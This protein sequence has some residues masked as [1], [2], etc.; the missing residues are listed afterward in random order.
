MQS[1]HGA[2]VEYFGDPSFDDSLGEDLQ[3]I[4]LQDM[5]SHHTEAVVDLE[6]FPWAA[7]ISGQQAGP[8]A[9]SR[10]PEQFP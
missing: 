9:S 8:E 2:V 7:G 5:H 1:I 3:E 4:E 10:Q 6:E